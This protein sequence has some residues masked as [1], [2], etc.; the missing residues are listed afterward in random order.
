MPPSRNKT[1]GF[2]ET[3]YRGEY[4]ENAGF[5][6]K[7]HTA[8]KVGGRRK[9]GRKYEMDWPH[10]RGHSIISLQYRSWAGCWGLDIVAFT[11]LQDCQESELTQWHGTHTHTHNQNMFV[12]LSDQ[13][14]RSYRRVYTH[15]KDQ[16]MMIGRFFLND[17]LLVQ[18]RVAK[19]LFPASKFRLSLL[20]LGCPTLGLQIGTQAGFPVFSVGLRNMLMWLKK[21]TPQ[22]RGL[23]GLP[24]G[25]LKQP[26]QNLVLWMWILTLAASWHHV[27]SLNNHPPK[28]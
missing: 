4:H 18:V 5:F 10:K 17:F 1:S 19:L 8:Q 14:L 27:G 11:H 26:L 16:E 21:R 28:V 23:G 12:D 3:R 24:S 13:I 6:G 2:I 7:D 9:R 15:F 25:R 20:P 22:L